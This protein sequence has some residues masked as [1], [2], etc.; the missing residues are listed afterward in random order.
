MKYW[1]ILSEAQFNSMWVVLRV[2]DGTH[3]CII[4]FEDALK[5][6]GWLSCKQK[7]KWKPEV[8]VGVSGSRRKA[9][10]SF[11]GCKPFFS[12]HPSH[13]AHSCQHNT[14]GDVNQHVKFWQGF[15]KISPFL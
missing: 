12:P 15:A 4:F 2:S 3:R 10:I 14:V 11:S 1:L 5:T 6:L 13:V 7:E 9:V 8:V